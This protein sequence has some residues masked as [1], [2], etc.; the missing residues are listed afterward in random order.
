MCDPL[1][2]RLAG[3]LPILVLFGCNPG[4]ITDDGPA[5]PG[6]IVTL[7]RVRRLTLPELD[8]LLQALRVDSQHGALA[9]PADDQIKNFGNNADRLWV[10]PAF[11]QQYQ[12]LIQGLAPVAAADPQV[13]GCD[14]AAGDDACAA[15]FI[16][17]FGRRAWRR[18]L[19][20]D[21]QSTLKAL[22]DDGR[23]GGTFSDG[24]EL[25]LEAM[26]QAPELLYHYELGADGAAGDTVPLTPHELAEEL[27]FL[28][29]GAPPDDQLLALADGDTLSQADVRESEV[30]RL[31][32]VGGRAQLA[33]FVFSW[34]GLNRIDLA[35]KSPQVY[36]AWSDAIRSAM[37]EESEQFVAAA[38]LDDDGTLKTLLTADY[39][40]ADA[41]LA[42]Y[43][44]L[45]AP[46]AQPGVFARVPVDSTRA[47]ILT[48]GALLAGYAQEDESAPVRRGHMVRSQLFCQDMPPPPPSLKI[49]QPVSDPN[50]TTRQRFADHSNNPTCAGCHRLMD[51]IGFGF[52]S[53]DG[54][55]RFRSTE[56][57]Q[58]ID[59]HG[60]IIGTSDDDGDFDG[61]VELGQKLAA[62]AQVRA[63]LATNLLRFTFGRLDS[64]GDSR[65]LR[66][67]NKSFTADRR[68][69]DVLVDYVR[70]DEFASRKVEGQ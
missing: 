17:G 41:T 29:T 4:T 22:F 65:L 9:L 7:R 49:T 48:Q 3:T 54:A 58:P 66:S 43:Y 40:F 5:D 59:A 37:R 47:G 38:L 21:E 33:R 63:C 56:N 14:P 25:V 15:R 44:G 31:I 62:S 55:G 50:R 24:V 53:F 18:P 42:G 6:G 13:V 39:T 46:G 28:A 64:D 12:A 27:A 2:R 30:R 26:L 52:E 20:S 19:T 35:T 68:I 45:A 16:D 36:P 61:A 10:S 8:A 57:G 60:S 32:G 70:A 51:P 69:T 67:I 34:L 23:S 1:W 11:A